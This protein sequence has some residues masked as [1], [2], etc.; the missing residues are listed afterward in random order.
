[1]DYPLFLEAF[2]GLTQTKF[3]F[4]QNAVT[5]VNCSHQNA[6]LLNK[7]AFLPPFLSPTTSNR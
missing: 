7:T 1:M 2:Y 4:N 3:V 5:N 6:Y